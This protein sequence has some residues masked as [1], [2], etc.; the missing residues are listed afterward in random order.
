MDDLNILLYIH[1]GLEYFFDAC[2]LKLDTGAN[3]VE[4][5]GFRAK[6]A[7]NINKILYVQ[8]VLFILLVKESVKASMAMHCSFKGL[9]FIIQRFKKKKFLIYM[10][11]KKLFVS[12]HYV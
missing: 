10:P 1:T 6:C 5:L 12:N 11:Y 9:H 8:E 3:A 7:N 4:L 2:Y